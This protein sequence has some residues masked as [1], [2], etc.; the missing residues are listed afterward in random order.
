MPGV[1]SAA[2]KPAASALT[3]AVLTMG[4]PDMIGARTTL[5]FTA[6]SSLPTLAWVRKLASTDVVGHFSQRT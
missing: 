5:P 2:M 6:S 4:W 3:R 1:S